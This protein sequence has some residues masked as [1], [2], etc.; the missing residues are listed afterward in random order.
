MGPAYRIGA[1]TALA[2]S[3]GPRAG[4]RAAA[5]VGPGFRR[6]HPGL[7]SQRPQAAARP[8]TPRKG[9]FG[10][11]PRVESAE[12]GAPRAG[13]ACP[14]PTRASRLR[15]NATPCRETRRPAQAPR[16]AHFPQPRRLLPP[17]RQNAVRAAVRPPF[18]PIKKQHNP[19]Q[20]SR[21]WRQ[22]RSI[23]AIRV[24]PVARA[25]RGKNDPGRGLEK[26]FPGWR[27]PQAPPH[28]SF[29]KSSLRTFL[30]PHLGTHSLVT[31]LLAHG[32]RK[33]TGKRQGAGGGFPATEERRPARR[34][35]DG[36]GG[37]SLE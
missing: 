37:F 34:K 21:P 23:P 6:L 3:P 27:L 32:R 16:S 36:G 31:K 33:R 19:R 13:A 7:Y 30:C 2:L 9:D 17:A 29:G 14:S 20:V 8:P 12:P 26:V 4:G 5:R 1:E 24:D 18:R 35:R 10:I 15:R 22:V 25:D 28:D 11:K